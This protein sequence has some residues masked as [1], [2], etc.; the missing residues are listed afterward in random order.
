MVQKETESR[1]LRR[2]DQTQGLFKPQRQ[3]QTKK[4]EEPRPEEQFR[5]KRKKKKLRWPRVNMSPKELNS[6]YNSKVQSAEWMTRPKQGTPTWMPNMY[7]TT[8]SGVRVTLDDGRKF[9]VHKGPGFGKSSETVVTDARHMSDKWQVKQTQAVGGAHTVGD[10]VKT[11]GENY[12]IFKG[13]HC[14][15]AAHDMMNQK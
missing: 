10:Y 1:S 2:W 8:H 7:P 11:G 12:S 3:Q 4:R 6:L 15:R 9:M 14:H 13:Q 5:K